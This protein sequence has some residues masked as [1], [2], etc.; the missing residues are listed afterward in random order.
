MVS[1]KFSILNTFANSRVGEVRKQI[2]LLKGDLKLAGL[3]DLKD[4]P[5]AKRDR[6][7][8]SMP[9]LIKGFFEFLEKEMV[10]NRPEIVWDSNNDFK[11]KF[12]ETYN[13][14]IT[15][16]SSK[17]FRE[18][19]KQTSESLKKIDAGEITELS[20]DER[21][22]LSFVLD[23][24]NPKGGVTVLSPVDGLYILSH[25]AGLIIDL[26]VNDLEKFKEIMGSR[27]VSIFTNSLMIN[28]SDGMS[29]LMG[30][31][32]QDHK[33][34]E[35]KSTTYSFSK[36]F[37]II[38]D[39]GNLVLRKDILSVVRKVFENNREKIGEVDRRNCPASYAPK[40]T[41]EFFRRIIEE[42]TIQYSKFLNI[43]R[44]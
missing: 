21:A 13:V 37:F 43:V 8:A 25:I 19:G 22:Y 39:T 44:G 3:P 24:P 23:D 12:L 11:V 10:N 9:I 6:Y 15:E 42:L 34:R 16:L 30:L 33:T 27:G 26:G 40:E 31:L 36:D 1:P 38:S 18:L 2:E 20:E 17:Y 5:V 14:F 35:H 41:N 7:F 28:E 32:S 29:S 4:D